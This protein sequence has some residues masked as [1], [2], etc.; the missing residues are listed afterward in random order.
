MLLQYLEKSQT[1]PTKNFLGH[2]IWT[3]IE[4]F[5]WTNKENL[6]T[7]T[8]I[9]NLGTWT[10]IE[11]LG[12]WTNKEN[13]KIEHMN[14][15]RVEYPK[16]PRKWKIKFEFEYLFFHLGQWKSFQKLRKRCRK[17]NCKRSQQWEWEVWRENV[18]KFEFLKIQ[19]C[20]IL[21]WG[22]QKCNGGDVGGI[23]LGWLW[24]SPW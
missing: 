8:N 5:L 17:R 18:F 9:E 15:K 4:F 10:N 1:Q 6:G 22:A 16:F 2:Q 21:S 24:L 13:W 23:P 3:N 19:K 11:N 12:T 7:W 14:Q 20:E